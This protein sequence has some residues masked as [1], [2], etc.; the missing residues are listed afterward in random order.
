M[1]RHVSNGTEDT[2]LPNNLSREQLY[3]QLYNIVF[4]DITNGVYEVGDLI[5]SE[6]EY[7]QKFSVSRTTVADQIGRASCRE[8]V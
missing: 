3:Y 6:T 5:P 1:T 7:M 4:Q 8:R 2:P